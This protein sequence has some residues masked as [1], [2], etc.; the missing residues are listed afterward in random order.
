MQGPVSA[1]QPGQPAPSFSLPAINRDGHVSLADFSGRSALLIGLFRGLH[2]PFCRRQI[3][4]LGTIQTQLRGAGV[5]TVAVINTPVERGRLYYRH[6]PNPAILLSDAQ[7][8]THRAFGVQKIGFSAP[9][10]DAPVQ[11]PANVPFEYFDAVRINP[12]ELM[13]QPASPL[14]ANELLNRTDG[15]TLTGEDQQIFD[16]HG[17]QLSGY[18]VVDSAGIVRWGWTEAVSGPGE[19]CKYPSP[20][21][22]VAAARGVG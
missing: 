3:V 4:Q 17:S 10:S 2:C 18:F 11:W 22:L 14:G 7:C 5:E 6:Q 1:I 16:A 8:A 13:P 19:L 20:A 12:G 21:E 9:G 15:F